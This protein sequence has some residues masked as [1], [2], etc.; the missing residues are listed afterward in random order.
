MEKY[1]EVLK[2]LYDDP[3][4]FANGRD[5][6]FSHAKKRFANLPKEA[7]FEFLQKQQT[8]QLNAPVRKQSDVKPLVVTKPGKYLQCDLIDMSSLSRTNSG[9]KFV[10]T[11]IDCHSKYL[12]AIPLKYKTAE[13][14]AKALTPIIDKTYSKSP[15]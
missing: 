1:D 15:P 10:L 8:Y 4:T 7:V 11:V 3:K 9:I 2:H 6:F 14:V 12:W 13:A 5:S